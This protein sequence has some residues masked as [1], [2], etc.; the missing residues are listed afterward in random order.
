V[1]VVAGKD[2]APAARATGPPKADLQGVRAVIA[3]SFERIHR[4]N[5]V[6]MGIL[7]LSSH[8]AKTCNRWPEGRRVV[9]DQGINAIKPG[10]QVE[11]EATRGRWQETTCKT[12]ARVDNDTEVDMCTTA[13]SYRWCY[14]S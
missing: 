11:V 8:A 14:G 5:L 1:I 13:A 4:S 3:E 10:Q 6:G 2:M 12:H 7:H 9:H